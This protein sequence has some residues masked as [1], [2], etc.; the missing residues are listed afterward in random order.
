MNK[1]IAV[2]SMITFGVLAAGC[3]SA[4]TSAEVREDVAEAQA[5]RAENVAEAR[6]DGAQAIERQQRD[7]TAERRDVQIATATRNYEVAV[8]KADGDYRIATQA[9]EALTGTDQ[10]SCKDEADAIL[11]VETARA[12]LLKPRG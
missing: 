11:K 4:D 8:S 1:V 2:G 6:N 7:V 9:C 5:E 3:N 12:E 10:A